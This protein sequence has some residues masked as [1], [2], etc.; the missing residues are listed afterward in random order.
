MFPLVAI[1]DGVRFV[2]DSEPADAGNG[3]DDARERSLPPL[4][5]WCVSLGALGQLHHVLCSVL[6]AEH[7]TPSPLDGDD[8]PC[9][10]YALGHTALISVIKGLNTPLAQRC[11]HLGA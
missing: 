2:E 10:V 3:Q 4:R 8:G 1:V 5:E 9:R 11:Y 6:S 7:D